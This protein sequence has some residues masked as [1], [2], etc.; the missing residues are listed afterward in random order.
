ML[1]ACRDACTARDPHEVGASHAGFEPLGAV[2]PVHL[3]EAIFV[4]QQAPV[5]EGDGDSVLIAHELHALLHRVMTVDE[6]HGAVSYTH[7][8]LPTILRV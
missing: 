8:T 3:L 1:A 2:V 6:A 4:S 7:L 5:L